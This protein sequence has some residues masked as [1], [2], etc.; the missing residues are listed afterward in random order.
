M[1][2]LIAHK[3]PFDAMPVSQS[4]MEKHAESEL[5]K[6]KE[7]INHYTMEYVLLNNLG[8]CKNWLSPYDYRYFGKYV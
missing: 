5:R 7:N 1:L 6:E 4:M 8:N 3:L 2:E